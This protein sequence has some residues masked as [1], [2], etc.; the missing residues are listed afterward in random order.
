MGSNDSFVHATPV[1]FMP[2]YKQILSEKS[3]VGS[4]ADL[5]FKRFHESGIIDTSFVMSNASQ[6]PVK[7]TKKNVFLS[8]KKCDVPRSYPED[9][10][11][12]HVY[13]LVKEYMYDALHVPVLSPDDEMDFN[14]STSPGRR[15]K[16]MGFQNKK[17]VLNCP[18]VREILHDFS[19]PIHDVNAKNEILPLTEILN[20]KI[21]TTFNAPLGLLTHQKL[22]YDNQNANLLA[23]HSDSF[24][25]YGLSKEYGGFDKL[26]KEFEEYEVRE[27]D[28]CIGYDRNAE[29]EEVY[30][31][32]NECLIYPNI[33]YYQFLIEW[34]TN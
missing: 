11:Q 10:M 25:K 21:R 16:A 15:L 28:D 17:E 3:P 33:D 20:D 6:R 19:L 24:I 5:H 14:T 4:T 34:V 31:L 12:G 29:L 22:L 30:K 9:E 32:R 8:A 2:I 27:T 7:A 1:V 26:G 13:S 23:S 18:E